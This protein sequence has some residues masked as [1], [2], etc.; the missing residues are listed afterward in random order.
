MRTNEPTTQQGT[1]GRRIKC[2]VP[3]GGCEDMHQSLEIGVHKLSLSVYAC[4]SNPPEGRLLS[5]RSVLLHLL[6][7][8]CY[9]RTTYLRIKYY[10]CIRVNVLVRNQLQNY[11]CR[12]PSG[13]IYLYSKKKTRLAEIEIGLLHKPTISSTAASSSSSHVGGKEATTHLKHGETRLHDCQARAVGCGVSQARPAAR[14]RR[15]TKPINRGRH[16]RRGAI[17]RQIN[18]THVG[19]SGGPAGIPVPAKV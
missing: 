5:V 16:G 15:T 3:K 17:R 11:I 2:E 13:H 19:F 4:A 18:G 10:C 12:D 8:T 9:E 7:C 14:Q 1:R 6:C